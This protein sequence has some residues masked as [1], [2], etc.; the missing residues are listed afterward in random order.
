MP[1]GHRFFISMLAVGLAV[2]VTG[3]GGSGHA[4]VSSPS[5][6]ASSAPPA[7]GAT[8]TTVTGTGSGASGSITLAGP[9]S[10]TYQ[11]SDFVV[12]CAVGSSGP[13]GQLVFGT[14]SSAVSVVFEAKTGT[15]TLPYPADSDGVQVVQGDLENIDPS[16]NPPTWSSVSGATGTLTTSGSETGS[17]RV[18]V[19]AELIPVKTVANVGEEAIS[20]P[21]LQLSGSW[22]C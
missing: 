19:Q 6:S 5:T 8:S 16:S 10:G 18:T 1:S 9:L 12:P 11:F 13:S 2:A 17:I 21:K 4:S 14:G 20:G 22:T 7:A 15:V 3:C